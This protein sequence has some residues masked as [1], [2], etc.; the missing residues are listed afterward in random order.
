[1]KRK[2]PKL[3]KINDN[4]NQGNTFLNKKSPTINFQMKTFFI[5][6]FISLF[7]FS[8]MAQIKGSEKTKPVFNLP[9]GL[10]FH[11]KTDTTVDYSYKLNQIPNQD[12]E[13]FKEGDF[14]KD[15]PK[16]KLDYYQKNEPENFQYYLK[17]KAFYDNLSD[18]VKITFTIEELW[19]VYY[20]DQ[21]LKS[22]LQAIK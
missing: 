10:S 18:K 19:Y 15:V 9:P 7:A 1:M 16:Y 12:P 8:G 17:A 20:F 11:P 13:N 3:L 2:L 14:F 6:L 4:V 21:K 22:T 5:L